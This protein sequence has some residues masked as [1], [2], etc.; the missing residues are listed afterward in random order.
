MNLDRYIKELRVEHG[1][2][3]EMI[4]ALESIGASRANG[5]APVKRGRG[6]PRKDAMPTKIAK[7]GKF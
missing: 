4:K 6:R 1:K 3:D 5:G 2:I 7:R